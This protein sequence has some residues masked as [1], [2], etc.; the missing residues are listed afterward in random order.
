MSR[1][2]LILF[3][4]ILFTVLQCT[5]LDYIRIFKTKP[6]ILLILVIFFSLYYGQ[7]Y[8]LA[9]GAL[10]GMFSEATSGIPS[11]II[12]L[13]YSIGGIVLG[14]MGRWVYLAPVHRGGGYNQKI[15]WQMA[16]SFIFTFTVYL[17]LFLILHAT[18]GDLSCFKALISVILP[19]S[20]YTAFI[21]PLVFL[22]LGAGFTGL[23]TQPIE[24]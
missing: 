22:A 12:V 2:L 9:V 13:V 19:S 8:G 18:K 5:V 6:D 1:K 16:V 23:L 4:I 17:S 15:L 3:L 21:A 24:T 20:F 10:S 11:G 7:R 14:R